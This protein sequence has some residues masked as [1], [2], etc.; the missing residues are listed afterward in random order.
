MSDKAPDDLGERIARAKAAREPERLAHEKQAETAISA[1]G[2]ALRHG[3]EMAASVLVGVVLG[4]GIDNFLGT[5]PWG[6]LIMLAFGLAAGILGVI[7]AYKRINAEI[8]AN[9]AN[10]SAGRD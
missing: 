5:K 8:A 2:L 9:D 7:R 3:T 1:G 6:F 10:I 4:L